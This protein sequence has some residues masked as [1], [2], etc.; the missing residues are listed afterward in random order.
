MTD[1]TKRKGSK[2][3]RSRPPHNA[4]LAEHASFQDLLTKAANE[5]RAAEINGREIRLSRAERL[6]R[7]S[8]DR[9][10]DG[11]PRD[12]ADILRRMIDTPALAASF[13]EEITYYFH[14]SVA[15][16]LK[17]QTGRKFSMEKQDEKPERGYEVGYK[18]PPVD[19]Q[20]KTGEKRKPRTRSGTGSTSRT[21]LYWRI[22]QERHRL[23]RGSKVVWMTKAELIVEKAFQLAEGGNPTLNRR[24]IDLLLVVEPNSDDQL[25][26]KIEIDRDAPTDFYWR[27]NLIRP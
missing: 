19:H 27:K 21:E 9:A 25:G 3:G 10:L 22:L 2:D 1:N 4:R 8:I 26:Y 5:P 14:G 11:S 6:F 18:K 15:D 17:T 20:F 7:L 23:P 24:L 13:R 16:F 12:L